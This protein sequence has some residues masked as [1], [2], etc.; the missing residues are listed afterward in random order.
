MPDVFVR[1]YSELGFRYD[2]T[3][4]FKLRLD[5]QFTLVREVGDEAS[6]ELIDDTWNLGIRASTSYHGA[7][8]RLG[9]SFT[10]DN[11]SIFRFYGS[12][13]SYVDLMQRAF[14]AQGEKALLASVS[15]DFGHIGVK[16]LSAIVNFVAAFDGETTDVAGDDF[17]DRSGAAQE[18]DLTF[19]Y[20][21]RSGLLESFWLRLRA[22]WLAE[23]GAPQDGTDFRVILRYDF[24][25]M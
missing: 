20:K 4:R 22:S 12:S 25:V 10:G 8:F 24:P 23:N 17:F 7:V 3:D 16:G 9:A 18:I 5:G 19:D 2:V 1:F 13:P 11:A 6:R 15:Y 14:L 21:I